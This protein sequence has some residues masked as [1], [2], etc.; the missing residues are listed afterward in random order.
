V[1]LAQL[2]KEKE[3]LQAQIDAI[4]ATGQIAQYSQTQIKER[5]F[6]ANDVARRLL[7]DFREVEENFRVIARQVQEQQLALEARKGQIVQHVLEAAFVSNRQ[8]A[9]KLTTLIEQ[10]SLGIQGVHPYMVMR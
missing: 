10:G 4:Q 9:A 6:A 3:Q 8:K 7:G 2:E 1:R 5:F